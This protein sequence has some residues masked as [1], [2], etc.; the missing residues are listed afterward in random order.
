MIHK[1]V[2][3]IGTV[4]IPA[5]YGGFE[6]LTEYLT[7]Y[8][9]DKYDITVFSSAKSY[10]SKLESHN[11]AKLEYINLHANG[12]QSILYDIISIFRSLRFADTL[13]IL[14]VSGCIVLPFVR[15]F[16]KKRIIVN[17]D[18]LEWKREKWG[19]G[20]KWF[21]KFSEKLAVKYADAVVS[22]NKVIQEYVK[23]EYG[24]ES[25]LI[26]YGAD[27]V[28]LEP[29]NEQLITQ[30]P[31]LEQHYAFK[32][33]RI[34]PENNIHMI[35]EAF[36]F[37]GQL[38]FIVIGNWSN[39]EYGRMLKS[40]YIDVNNIFLLDPIYDQKILN[41]FRSNCRLYVHGHSAGGTNPSL[42]E[43]MY[44]GLPIMAYGVEYNNATTHN[45]AMYFYNAQELVGLLENV[46]DTQLCGTAADLQ[47]IARN[48][49]TWAK[50]TESYAKL[51]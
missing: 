2:A 31:Y 43:A 4:G 35:L 14:G 13:L 37:F 15:L 30:Y 33:C 3:I 10:A 46:N 47:A 42:V 17:I 11:G 26:A 39:S 6:T 19:K 36:K 21:L 41:Q 12:V 40:H 29:L 50:I 24:K 34:E 25:V 1:K 45:K 18:G 28:T 44:L 16:S 9:S 32:V 51:F 49:Y 20:A 5:K 27:H 22:D 8:L 38:N 7:K 48:E 23:I